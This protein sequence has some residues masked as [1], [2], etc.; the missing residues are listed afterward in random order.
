VAAPR[1]CS[2]LLQQL[3]RP[4]KIGIMPENALQHSAGAGRISC[5]AQPDGEIHADVAGL[6]IH[7]ERIAPQLQRL[8]QHS[9]LGVDDAKICSRKRPVR[10]ARERAFVKFCRAPTA[11]LIFNE[12][13]AVFL[14][15]DSNSNTYE[16]HLP[17]GLNREAV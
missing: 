11:L 16:G 3:P 6:R 2:G 4:A 9:V 10:S 15:S 13:L 12:T 17:D 14:W 1:T 7:F 5:S 8:C